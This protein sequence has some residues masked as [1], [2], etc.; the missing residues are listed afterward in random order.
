[1]RISENEKL[2]TLFEN[3][4]LT[5]AACVGVGGCVGVCVCVCGCRCLCGFVV[6][7]GV[8]CGRVGACVCVCGSGCVFLSIILFFLSFFFFFFAEIHVLASVIVW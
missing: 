2:G 5:P 6:G 7:V 1:M 3:N 8:V 4:P